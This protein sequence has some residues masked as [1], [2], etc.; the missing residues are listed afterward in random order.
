VRLGSSCAS[1]S[2]QV[3]QV[4]ALPLVDAVKPSWMPLG[5]LGLQLLQ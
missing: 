2:L 1:P 4:Q 3:K 5:G